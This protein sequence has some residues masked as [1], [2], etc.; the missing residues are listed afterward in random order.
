MCDQHCLRSA[1]PYA[2]SD[3]SLC[4]LVEYS[5]SVKLLTEHHLEL[6]SLKGDCTGSSESKLV[7][8]PHSCKSHVA[9]QMVL[10]GEMWFVTFY[11]ILLSL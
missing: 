1:C 9:A 4:K 7:K 11:W 8:M 5:V 10:S 3:Q 6:P 2:Q